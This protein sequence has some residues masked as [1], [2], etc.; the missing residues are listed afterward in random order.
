MSTPPVAIDLRHLRYF[1]A[2]IEELHFGRAAERLH[3]A[4]PPLSQAIR[5]LE[6]ELG[7]QLLHR[8]SRHVVATEP[9][10]V[11]AEEA[12]KVLATF[13]LAVAE[14]RRAGGANAVVRIGASPFLAIERLQ[15]V[16]NA[17]HE[18][19]PS[20]TTRVTHLVSQEQRRRLIR[21]ELDVGIFQ[22]VGDVAGLV[23]EPLFPGEPLAVF[24]PPGHR[25]ERKDH[26][27]PEDVVDEIL[28]TYPRSEN[29][30]L[31]DRFYDLIEEAGYEFLDKREASGPSERD[32]L[33]AVSERVGILLAT[34]SLKEITG[35][36]RL[37]V[38]RPLEP[39]ISMPETV[40]AW[41]ANPPSQLDRVL[42]TLRAVA[43]ELRAGGGGSALGK[44]DPDDLDMGTP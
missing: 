16:L 3:I 6:N 26:V 13:D 32:L 10:N 14:A 38:R 25:L 7:V 28:V 19:D 34:H 20:L 9:G 30:T 33:L 29:P 23:T 44:G 12:R 27:C 15:A 43:R 2:V 24:I 17:I 22:M 41:R 35:A 37:V 36:G 18:R 42:G 1:L 5:K 11:F 40:I 8:T 21:G 31:H 4:Q 39:R